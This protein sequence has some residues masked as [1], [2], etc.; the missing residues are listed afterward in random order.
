MN[1][2]FFSFFR[3]LRN[4]EFRSWIILPYKI[5]ARASI[6]SHILYILFDNILISR[7]I[8]YKELFVF[9]KIIL[10]AVESSNIGD[11]LE[12]ATT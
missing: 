9:D 3:D 10:L 8:G 5:T 2:K 12:N 11:M 1:N 6:S 4:I 7:N